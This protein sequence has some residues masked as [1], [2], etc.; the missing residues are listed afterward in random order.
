MRKH[1]T[2]LG[3]I[4]SSLALLVLLSASASALPSATN[5]HAQAATTTGSTQAMAARTAAQQKLCQV[6]EKVITNIITRI[7]TRSAN[8]IQLFN[9]IATRV[10][11]FYV[12]KGNTLSNYGALTAAVTAADVKAKTDFL[13]LNSGSNFT[14]TA[15][16]P[17]AIITGFQ[18]YLKQEISDLQ[19]LRTAVKNLIVGV[20]HANGLNLS[21]SSSSSSSSSST[22][23]T[24]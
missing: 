18:S 4:S 10:E 9:S 17:K 5:G 20:A 2:K 22:G 19:N 14:C 15:N 7:D 12:K 23:S 6:R 13:T 21:G 16:D 3:V 8:Q 1:T 11:A 24:N